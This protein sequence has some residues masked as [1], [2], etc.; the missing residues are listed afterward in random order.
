MSSQEKKEKKEIKDEIKVILSEPKTQKKLTI[1]SEKLNIT[2]SNLQNL[3]AK[4]LFR[5]VWNLFDP[6]YYNRDK[7]INYFISNDNLRYLHDADVVY[8]LIDFTNSM[9]DVVKAY[10]L[11]Y[12]DGMKAYRKYRK[13]SKGRSN[14]KVRRKTSRKTSRKSRGKSYRN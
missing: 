9:F 10:F 6:N 5:Y 1:L 14:K 2:L 3:M 7:L 8:K 4:L 13:K 12:K 11:E